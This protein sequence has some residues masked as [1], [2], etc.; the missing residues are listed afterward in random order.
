MPVRQSWPRRR[1][2][3]GRRGRLFAVVASDRR[4]TLD[5]RPVMPRRRTFRA[6]DVMRARFERLGV[7]PEQARKQA[8]DQE[9]EHQRLEGIADEELDVA[10]ARGGAKPPAIF[11]LSE[12]ATRAGG[13]PRHHRQVRGVEF[14]PD[15]K[16]TRLNSSH[17]GIS[18]AVFCLKK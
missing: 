12:R 3:Q 15:R 5:G 13:A 14:D 8:A 2:P 11:Q 1:P 10:T 9:L 4:A 18:Y 16:S 17:L 7:A 6:I